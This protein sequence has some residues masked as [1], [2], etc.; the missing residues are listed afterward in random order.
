[1][2][3][4]ITRIAADAMG[5]EKLEKA[6]GLSRSGWT[7]ND[8]RT[9][10]L[11]T[12]APKAIDALEKLFEAVPRELPRVPRCRH[13]IALY[14]K[15]QRDPGQRARNAEQMSTL[16]KMFLQKVEG[17]RI[18][19]SDGE[20]W[21]AYYVN[22]VR[23]HP[24]EHMRGE[25]VSPAWVGVELAYEF[26]GGRT[27]TKIRLEEENCRNVTPQMALQAFGYVAETPELRAAYLR[28]KEKFDELQPQIGRQLESWGVGTDDLDGNNDEDGDDDHWSWWRQVGKVNTGTEPEPGRL[29]VDVFK[30]NPKKDDDDDDDVSLDA[31]FWAHNKVKRLTDDFEELSEADQERV[32]KALDAGV[33]IEVPL[34]PYLATFDLKRHK[35]LRVHV[36][37]VRVHEYDKGLSDKLV[38]PREMKELVK[39]LIEHRAGGFRDIV[40]G[41]SGGAVVLLAGP[42][43]TGK[44]LTAEVYAESEERPLYSVQCS[45]LGVSPKDLEKNLARCFRRA[46]RWNAVMLLDEADVYVRKRGDD[47]NQNAIVGVFLRVLEYQGAVLFL[48]TNRPEDVDDAIASRCV[49]KLTYGAPNDVEQG[50]IWSILAGGAGIAMAPKEIAGFVKAN[51]GLSGRD[52]KNLLKLAAL[53]ARGKPVEARTVEAVKK[54]KPTTS[55]EGR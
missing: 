33:Q 1:M 38:L 45:Q 55:G 39:L 46:A 9:V 44:T 14:K 41:K 11:N 19:K 10:D 48:T 26:L 32:Q 6:I 12:L 29:V 16:M 17:H 22:K 47:L 50:L 3:L 36:N 24:K 20:S 53:M 2:N 31:M 5:L 34:H 13:D 30:E 25:R 23:F 37:N 7:Y 21:L 42:P 40:A 35:R 8:D 27:E 52:V 49:A 18:Y 54:F 51:P 43:G 15:A 28:E 4:K